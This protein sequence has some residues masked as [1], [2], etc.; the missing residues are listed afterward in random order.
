MGKLEGKVAVITKF[1]HIDVLFINAG[2]AMF[3]PVDAV[4]EELFDLVMDVNF[5][6]AYFTIQKALPL[7]N[8]NLT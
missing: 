1:G 8:D 6:G 7:L 3:A 5:K 4:T 2:V